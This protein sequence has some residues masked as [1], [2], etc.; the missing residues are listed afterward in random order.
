MGGGGWRWLHAA[1]DK[2]FSSLVKVTPCTRS[3]TGR[4][5]GQIFL[6]SDYLVLPPLLF[7]VLTPPAALLG[8][9]FFDSPRREQPHAE[10]HDTNSA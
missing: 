1:D 6:C 5:Q 9:T 2:G 3:E 8:R 10:V 7:K 4:W